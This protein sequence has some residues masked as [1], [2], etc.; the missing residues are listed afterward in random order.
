MATE[1]GPL[2]PF[3]D[4]M[5][6]LAGSPVSPRWRRWFLN[7]RQSVDSSTLAVK[8]E[9]KTDQTGAL[10]ITQLDGGNLSAGLFAI[11]WYLSVVTAQAASTAQVTI[12]WIDGTVSR[13]FTGALFDG[14]IAA[15]TQPDER[16][17]IYADA[18]TPISYAVNYAGTF[19][20]DLR[21]VLQSV[22]AG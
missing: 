21:I 16:I 8:T 3:N 22:S 6:A 17:M 12:A 14:S 2:F 4:D 20:Y 5:T 15:N 7:L 9:T 19:S 18:G 1:S 10:P 11:S 13:S